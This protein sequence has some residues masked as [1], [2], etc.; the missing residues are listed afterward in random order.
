MFV[1]VISTHQVHIKLD[2]FFI[3]T[4]FIFI[5]T[6]LKTYILKPIKGSRQWSQLQ[7]KNPADIDNLHIHSFK[8]C[9]AG[10]HIF[11]FI[12]LQQI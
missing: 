11:C 2:T 6:S 4:Y 8:F 7:Q 1:W 10:L 9:F 3:Y 5:D 12:H